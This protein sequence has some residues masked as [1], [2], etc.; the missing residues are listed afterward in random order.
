[1]REGGERRAS[2]ID[3]QCCEFSHAQRPPSQA[4]LEAQSISKN[5]SVALKV[6][7]TL[8]LVVNIAYTGNEAAAKSREEALVGT[9]RT[10]LGVVFVNV[11]SL[12][13][14][15]GTRAEDE[16]ENNQAEPS[17]A[18]ERGDRGR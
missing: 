14:G 3:A 13:R 11:S 7:Q 16:K 12:L 5:E 4:A 18:N 6:L 15:G 10:L 8:P 17:Q 1:M 2:P 9:L